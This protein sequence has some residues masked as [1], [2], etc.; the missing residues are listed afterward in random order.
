V[1]GSR[2]GL[3]LNAIAAWLRTRVF[4]RR[5]R[6]DAIA[7][8]VVRARDLGAMHVRVGGVEVTFS[9]LPVAPIATDPGL[10]DA[11]RKAAAERDLMWSAQ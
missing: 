1:V 6:L 4:A 11:E 2:V 10:T 8:F 3:A 5:S 7:A 9:A